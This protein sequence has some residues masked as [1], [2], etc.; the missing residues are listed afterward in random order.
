MTYLTVSQPLCKQ[1][2]VVPAET[3]SALCSV[4]LDLACFKPFHF[5]EQKTHSLFEARR[6]T[7]HV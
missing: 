2:Q 7:V 6:L 1:T 4:C 5:F 3:N